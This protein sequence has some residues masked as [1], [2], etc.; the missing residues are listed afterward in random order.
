[1]DQDFVCFL[2]PEKFFHKTPSF[3]G[4]GQGHCERHRGMSGRGD[5]RKLPHQAAIFKNTGKAERVQKT[6][7]RQYAF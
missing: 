7:K 2:L 6:V 1:L 3:V 4:P 5:T